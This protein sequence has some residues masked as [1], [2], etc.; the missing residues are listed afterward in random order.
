MDHLDVQ[1]APAHG[2]AAAA[3]E[4]S[5]KAEAPHLSRLLRDMII[6]SLSRGLTPPQVMR[7]MRSRKDRQ[8]LTGRDSEVTL[9]DVRNI[10][11]KLEHLLWRLHPDAA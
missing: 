6:N 10:N 11:T 9:Q 8:E 3:A 2:P 1:G 7:D 4:K 5:R